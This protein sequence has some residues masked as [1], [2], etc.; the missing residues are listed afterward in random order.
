M[1]ID[2]SDPATPGEF[3]CDV[4]IVGA[5]AAGITIAKALLGSNLRVLLLEGG[6]DE[7]SDQSQEIYKGEITGL[8][9]FDLDWARLRFFGGSTNHW[10]G[11]CVP[12]SAIDFTT[13]PW[14]PFSG[15]PITSDDLQPYYQ[16]AAQICEIGA[17]Q[18]DDSLWAELGITPPKFNPNRIRTQ[19]WRRSRPTNFGVQ[20]RDELQRSSNLSVLLNCN[21]IEL[22]PASENRQIQSLK[23]ASFTGRRG[24]VKARFYVLAAGGIENARLLL[25]SRANH[26]NGLGNS[27]GYVG[28]FFMEHLCV[29]AGVV[30]GEQ[31]TGLANVMD[32]H[33]VNPGLD[34]FYA[35]W[36]AVSNGQI[37]EDV[38]GKL[39]RILQN[40]DTVAE[41]LYGKVVH[42]NFGRYL[43][44][45]ELRT[46]NP[47]V[48]LSEDVQV[49]EEVL[50]VSASLW[51]NSSG[52]LEVYL[53]SEQAPNPDS[54]IYLTDERDP[55][56]VPRISLDWRATEL[57]YRSALM[58]VK[59]L[60]AE[61]GRLGLGRVKVHD[62]LLNSTPTWPENLEGGYHHMGTTRMS[63][64]PA[65]GVVD[66]NCKCHDIENLFLAGSS[67]FPT[68][69]YANPTFTIVALALRLANHIKRFLA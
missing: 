68:G 20:Y 6:G 11:L 10:G 46:F 33:P 61:I 55:L 26:P 15:W 59:T 52:D 36:R 8:P 18:F 62:W 67:V 66:I 64:R 4:A 37:P 22:Q 41:A 16:A 29:P 35:S 3:E 28:R 60:A 17:P 14:V 19:F 44:L 56:G 2:Y 42:G 38:D 48:V 27:T 13:R 30:V 58:F 25:V 45:E 5:G 24:L 32:K 50:N 51:R 9:Y 34:S 65:D 57:D 23:I 12:L 49:Q 53:R 1:I 39:W 40:I 69:G 63:A 43:S 21:L 54:R 7:V 31:A 47:Q